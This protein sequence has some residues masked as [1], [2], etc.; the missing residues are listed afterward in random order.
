MTIIEGKEVIEFTHYIHSMKENGYLILRCHSYTIVNAG[1]ETVTIND[2]KTL[3][4]GAATGVSMTE[5]NHFIVDKL[6]I[7]FEGNGA[8]PRIEITEIVPYHPQLA[9]YVNQKK[10]N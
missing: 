8:N 3:P 2:V 5:S 7:V 6:K 4:R 10:I 9:H 1:D